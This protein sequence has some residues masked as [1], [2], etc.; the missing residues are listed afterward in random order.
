MYIFEGKDYSNETSQG[1]KKAYDLLLERQ[2]ALLEDLSQGGR[3]LR[4]KENVRI[5]R[6]FDIL[7]SVPEKAYL[8]FIYKHN[9][10]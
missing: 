10:K 1:D 2:K 7:I 8:K 4:N 3:I 5:M 9:R 6:H